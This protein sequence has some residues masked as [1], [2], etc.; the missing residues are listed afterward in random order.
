MSQNLQKN[1]L[2]SEIAT[3]EFNLTK[4]MGIIWKDMEYFM[5]PIDSRTSKG[6]E[7]FLLSKSKS[8]GPGACF[9]DSPCS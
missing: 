6:R 8:M 7:E 5:V 4:T 9:N 1:Q 2:F 3:V